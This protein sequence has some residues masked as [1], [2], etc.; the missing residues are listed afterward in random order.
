MVEC[1]S[2]CLS[3]N[4]LTEQNEVTFQSAHSLK[5]DLANVHEDWAMGLREKALESIT[6][7][8]HKGGQVK[9][10]SQNFFF[11]CANVTHTTVGGKQ[12]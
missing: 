12:P 1:P 9:L 4:L 10:C 7:K 6:W 8:Q 2:I 5:K 11:T 3:R